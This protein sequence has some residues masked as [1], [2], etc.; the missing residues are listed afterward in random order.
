MSSRYNLFMLHKLLEV[1]LVLDGFRVKYG[2]T[3]IVVLI[4]NCFRHCELF[5]LEKKAWQ[6]LELKT[7]F[8]C[9]LND[10]RLLRRSS[11]Q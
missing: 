10:N 4:L 11:S 2:K 3:K 8:K 7:H 6:S 1:T 5:S 9:I